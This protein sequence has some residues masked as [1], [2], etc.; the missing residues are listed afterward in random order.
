MKKKETEDT[1]AATSIGRREERL[2]KMEKMLESMAKDLPRWDGKTFEK[3]VEE[4]AAFP[5]Q[6]LRILCKRLAGK[7][8]AEQ[9]VTARAL[10]KMEGPELVER[11]KA[12]IFDV[13]PDAAKA[14]ANEILKLRG[15][16]PAQDELEMSLP[17]AAELAARMPERVRDDLAAGKTAEAADRFKALSPARQAVLIHGLGQDAPDLAAALFDKVAELTPAVSEAVIV[18]VA[19]NVIS[20]AAPV[21][22]RLAAGA[23][24]DLQKT[25]KRALFDMKAA[26]V[27]VPEIAAPAPAPQPAAKPAA[28]D[29]ALPVYK[30]CVSQRSKDDPCFLTLARERPDGRL[31]VLSVVA[32]FW[33]GGV[34]NAGFR[35]DMSKSAFARTLKNWERDQPVKDVPYEELK[36]LVVRGLAVSKVVGGPLPM[37]FQLGRALLE[38]LDEAVAAAGSPFRC[39]ECGVALGAEVVGQVRDAAVYSH[40]KVETRCQACR[41]A[42]AKGK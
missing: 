27:A 23:P 13:T 8:E 7:D 24:K 2:A 19:D 42:T 14:Q 20:A 1:A 39:S 3:I 16:A 30:A 9:A 17:N 25:A 36:K 38:P 34:R 12:V 37:D 28:A 10:A 6:A 31:K 33:R 15:A 21:V 41:N 18:C 40:V 5:Q 29:N 32:D 22:A 4:A 26:G 35:P 11:M